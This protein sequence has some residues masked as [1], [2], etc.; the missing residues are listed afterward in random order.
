MV[1]AMITG[2]QLKSAMGALG[3][4]V[5]KLA[6]RSGVGTSTITLIRKSDETNE[7][8]SF[9]LLRKLREELNKGLG[10]KGI[11]LDDKHVFRAK[12]GE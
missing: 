10:E 4:S 11:E 2:L 7:D 9:G 5:A 12:G 3:W 8:I 6:K 1:V